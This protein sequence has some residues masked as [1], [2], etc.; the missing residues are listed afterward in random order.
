MNT[1]NS[2]FYFLALAVACTQAFALPGSDSAPSNAKPAAASR[3]Q[4]SEP[5]R[6]PERKDLRTEA[7]SAAD[8]RA[9]R[10]SDLRLAL[11]PQNSNLK[12][13]GGLANVAD[14]STPEALPE[15][16]L[17]AKE[18]QEMRELLRQQR[19]KT[20]AGLQN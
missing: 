3:P 2:G 11:V 1:R 14:V 18:R 9:K 4:A 13:Q 19:L 7:V 5:H 12:P 6:A 20:Q 16:H 17:N 15:R 8:Q 10:G